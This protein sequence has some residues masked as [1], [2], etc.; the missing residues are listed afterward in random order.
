MKISKYLGQFFKEPFTA[1]GCL[2]VITAI[3]LEIYFKGTTSTSIFRQILLIASAYTFFKFALVNRYDLGKK[4]QMISFYICFILADIMIISWIWFFS[5]GK[6]VNKDYLIIYV[7]VFL[8]IKVLVYI[9]MHIDGRAQAKQL[10]ERLKEY[11]GSE[12]E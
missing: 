3:F 6:L 10:N 8:V 2:M 9:M 7:I 5:P 1:Y 4:A 11:N 12:S